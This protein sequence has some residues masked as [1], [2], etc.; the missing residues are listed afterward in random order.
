MNLV[1]HISISS[2]KVLKTGA[3]KDFHYIQSLGR[4]I[5]YELAAKE[6]ALLEKFRHTI[7]EI[8]IF[9]GEEDG[10]LVGENKFKGKSRF[11][12]G[13][14]KFWKYQF[15]MA[16]N[17]AKFD[18]IGNCFTFNNENNFVVTQPGSKGGLF[19][20]LKKHKREHCFEEQ[21]NC[22]HIM[23]HAPGTIPVQTSGHIIQ[24]CGSQEIF[25]EYEEH[26]HLPKPYGKCINKFPHEMVK[27][28]PVMKQYNYS[29]EACFAFKYT[30]EIPFHFSEEDLLDKGPGFSIFKGVESFQCFLE[31]FQ[32]IYKI[33][34]TR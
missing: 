24:L 14:K 6:P 5:N 21:C 27:T 19:L 31:C 29:I 34:A 2:I 30:M 25:Y 9:D 20:H 28:F 8:L 17:P 15:Q 1:A 11:S 13:M 12:S 16:V 10:Q 7:D 4:V 3:R 26:I 23:I 32:R 33:V 22:N 18:G